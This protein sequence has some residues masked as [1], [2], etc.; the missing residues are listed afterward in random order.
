M[1]RR[2]VIVAG[3]AVAAAA[4]AIWLVPRAVPIVALQQSLTRDAALARA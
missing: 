4:I 2:V 3:I 1:P